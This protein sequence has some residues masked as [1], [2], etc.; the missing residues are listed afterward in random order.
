MSKAKISF[1]ISMLIF[2]SIGLFVRNIPFTSSQI[3]LVRGLVGS[4]LLF[5]ASF[6]FT[7]RLSWKR[8]RPNLWLLAASGIALGMNWIFLFQAYHYTT[9][10]NA[11]ICY[12]F[13]PIFVMF[14]SPL[15]LKERLKMIN[16]LCILSAMAGMLCIV[17]IG[18]GAAATNNILGIGYGLT[19]AALYAIVIMINKFLKNISG[20]ESSFM[21]LLISAFSLFPYVL[22][23]DE[24]QIS[25]ASGTSIGLLVIVGVVHTGIAYLIYFSAL[26]KLSS[27]T[28]AA[29][30]YIDPISAI[31]MSSIFL[32]ENMT[33][34]QIFGGILILGAAF[35]NEMAGTKKE[36]DLIKESV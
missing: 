24:F 27:Q 1:I 20:I 10:A 7:Q 6:V 11:T 28:I 30:S 23:N 33:L 25:S 17:G 3:A 14:L 16:V 19:A 21:Q 5:A 12:Y 29:F 18:G 9:I 34:L 32:H 4:L 35:V 15:I 8:I 22:L 2:G 26:R 13:A 36:L 31:L